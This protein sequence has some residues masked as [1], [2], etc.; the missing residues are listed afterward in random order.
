MKNAVTQQPKQGAP[1]LKLSRE[2][3]A[4]HWREVVETGES[5]TPRPKG[6]LARCATSLSGALILACWNFR[7]PNFR[8]ASR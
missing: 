4:L 3:R 7:R 6:P 2:N 5:R 1:A 8:Q